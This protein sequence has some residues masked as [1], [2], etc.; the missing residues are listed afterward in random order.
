[1]EHGGWTTTTKT[2]GG[3]M[4][5]RGAIRQRHRGNVFAFVRYVKIVG[6]DCWRAVVAFGDGLLPD[7]VSIRF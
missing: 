4:P 6:V 1:M 2:V 5:D 3:V 7:N